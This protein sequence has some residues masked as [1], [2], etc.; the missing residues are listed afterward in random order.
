MIIIHAPLVTV[1][2]AVSFSAWA[3]SANH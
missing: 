2:V 3:C 1:L